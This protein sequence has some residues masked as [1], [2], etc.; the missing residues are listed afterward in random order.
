MFAQDKRDVLL[1]ALGLEF[2]LF[3][4]CAEGLADVIKIIWHNHPWL[5]ILLFTVFTL[6]VLALFYM[7]VNYLL[8]KIHDNSIKLRG[9]EK[10]ELV[11]ALSEVLDKRDK[12]SAEAN[13]QEI[14]QIINDIM[15]KRDTA[16]IRAFE[17]AIEKQTQ[18]IVAALQ[19]YSETIIKAMREPLDGHE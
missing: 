14:T 9:E 5:V 8:K 19:N 15:D 2:G 6:A 10:T 4:S 7:I 3:V 12:N 13:K 17:V 18:A 11:N 16:L 1:I